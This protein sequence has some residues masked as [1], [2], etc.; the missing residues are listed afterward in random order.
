MYME[1][2]AIY[3]PILEGAIRSKGYPYSLWN[4]EPQNYE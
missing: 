3:Q 1:I 4:G 2:L